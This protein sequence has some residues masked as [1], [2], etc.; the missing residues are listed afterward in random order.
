MLPWVL[1]IAPCVFVW[2]DGWT[3]RAVFFGVWASFDLSYTVL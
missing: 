2:I 3:D 1:A